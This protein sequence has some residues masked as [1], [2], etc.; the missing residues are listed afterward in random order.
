MR[1]GAETSRARPTGCCCPDKCVRASQLQALGPVRHHG[2]YVCPEQRM[3]FSVHKPKWLQSLAPQ[4]SCQAG[5]HLPGASECTATPHP[6][7]SPSRSGLGSTPRQLY[8]SVPPALQPGLQGGGGAAGTSFKWRRIQG[9]KQ[10]HGAVAPGA[11]APALR[12][13]RGA[14]ACKRPG[15]NSL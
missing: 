14:E 2:T 4:P 12:W 7:P 10:L 5:G 8:P 6:H 11:P 15:E 13:Q 3:Q 1:P 9:W